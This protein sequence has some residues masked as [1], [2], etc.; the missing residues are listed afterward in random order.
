LLSCVIYSEPQATTIFELEEDDR[1][2]LTHYNPASEQESGITS[3]LVVGLT[4]E[5]VFPSLVG[6]DIPNMYRAI[7]RGELEQQFYEWHSGDE[8][9]TGW[10]QVS[11]FQLCKNTV[12]VEFIDI[13]ALKLVENRNTETLQKLKASEAKSRN[14][15]KKTMNAFALHEL[16]YNEK[17]EAYD[18]RFLELNPAWEEIVGI[19]AEVVIGKTVREIMPGIDDTWVERYARIVETGIPEEF[20][21]FSHAAGKYFNCYAYCPEPGKFAVFFNDTTKSK[22]GEYSK[23]IAIEEKGKRADEL[24]LAN[25]ELAFQ[26]K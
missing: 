10:F 18:Y 9:F 25:I 1:L 6:T 23:K 16:I 2:V 12:G 17:G 4:I 13:S 20:E 22:Q 3:L 5:E 19:K 24:A 7:A 26:N 15:I 11:A 14:L 8:R 21:E